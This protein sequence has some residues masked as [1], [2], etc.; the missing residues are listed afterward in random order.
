M[1]LFM[2]EEEA[3]ALI[4]ENMD[5]I[6]ARMASGTNASSSQANTSFVGPTGNAPCDG[7]CIPEGCCNCCVC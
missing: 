6:E 5:Q 7:D 3:M 4:D 1:P 2:S